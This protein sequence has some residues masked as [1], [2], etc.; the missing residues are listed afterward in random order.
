MDDIAWSEGLWTHEPAHAEEAG[1]DLVVT[2]RPGSDAW[3]TTSYGFVHDS[4]HALLTPHEQDAAVEVSFHLDFSHQFDQA[5]VFLRI[6][7]ETWIK[8]GV[9]LS[10]GV[11]SL[12]AVVTRGESD[13]SLSPVAS[14]AGR[15]VTVRASRAGNAVTIRARVDS[16]PW[17]LVRVAPVDES[18]VVHSGP[19][20]C[21][22]SSEA[23]TVRFRSW[24]RS[25]ADE[26]LHPE[27]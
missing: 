22:P 9:E 27:G 16:D 3:R 11:E 14:W 2:A 21:A 6:D 8:A 4:E 25:A 18:A 15:R 5:G 1:S 17:Q 12:G 7:A 23:L 10:D 24:R 26:A 19:F 20:C 13:W